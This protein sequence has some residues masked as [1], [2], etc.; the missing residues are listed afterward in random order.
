MNYSSDT[1]IQGIINCCSGEPISVKDFVVNYLLLKNKHIDLNLGFYPYA[2]YE[3][4][5]FWGDNTK[6]KKIVS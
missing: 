5:E 2:D 4:M 6:L 3:P 1:K